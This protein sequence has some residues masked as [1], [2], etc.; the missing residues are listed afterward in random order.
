MKKF[1]CVGCENNCKLTPKKNYFL[2]KFCPFAEG[3][4]PV[5]HEV[6]EEACKIS[7]QD[8]R[9]S[10]Q[11]NKLPDWVK[12]G[13]VGYDALNNEYFEITHIEHDSFRAKSIDS[14]NSCSSL[15]FNEFVYEANKRPFNDKEMKSLVG[16]VLETP[17]VVLLV[18]AYGKISGTIVTPSGNYSAEALMDN[19]YTI[20]GKPCYVLEHLNEQ[21]QWVK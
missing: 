5:W 19:K 7:I 13:A 9:D 15:Y 18:N 20:D 6:K 8:N 2:P 14:S 10:I 1:E 4:E 16:R 12:V 21:G 3:Y 17:S 11:D